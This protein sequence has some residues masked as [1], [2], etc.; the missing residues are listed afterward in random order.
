MKRALRPGFSIAYGMLFA[1][2]LMPLLLQLPFILGLGGSLLVVNLAGAGALWILGRYLLVPRLAVR[3]HRDR[4]PPLW[5]HW[6]WHI[7]LAL[8]YVLWS[9]QLAPSLAATVSAILL[10]SHGG[11][12]MFVSLRPGQGSM[13]RLAAALFGIT[14]LKVLLLD[15]AS[16][17]LLHKVAA[18]MM[19]GLILLGVAYFYQLARNRRVSQV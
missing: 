13:V 6:G 12:L 2:V 19:I 5:L 15:M 14:C 1:C 7:L 17:A 4:V 3:W 16:F 9:Q 18:F 11:V 8:S 10:A